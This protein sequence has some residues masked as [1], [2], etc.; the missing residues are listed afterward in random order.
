MSTWKYTDPSNRVV[1]RTLADGSSESCVVEA[2]AEWIAEGNTPLPADPVPPPTIQEQ[3]DAIEDQF[4]DTL[5]MRA[6]LG[7]AT[8]IQTVTTMLAEIDALK[9]Q[10]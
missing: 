1:V 4:T 7:D 6:I 3:I 10:L 5:K 9:A 2:I 8:A